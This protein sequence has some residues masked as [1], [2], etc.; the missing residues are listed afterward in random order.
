MVVDG[1]ETTIYQFPV[2]GKKPLTTEETGATPVAP[3]AGAAVEAKAAPRGFLGIGRRNLTAEEITNP[4]VSR[5]LLDDYEE[6][7]RECVGL[8]AE[9]RELR[10][11]KETL[12]DQIADQRVELASLREKVVVSAKLEI[13]SYLCV[14]AGAAGLAACQGYFS[15]PAAHDLAI[16]GTVISAV[17]LLGGILVRVAWKSVWK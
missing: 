2:A 15:I 3:I 16:V 10:Q 12:K 14:S 7:E 4:I 17:L 11:Q 8:R 6:A 9:L 5:F 1:Y 13:L